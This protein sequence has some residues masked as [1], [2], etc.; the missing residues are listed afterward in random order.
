MQDT[1]KFGTERIV[2]M[3]DVIGDMDACDTLLDQ[4]LLPEDHIGQDPLADYETCPG[5]GFL[6]DAVTDDLDFAIPGLDEG[7]NPLD[8]RD[9]KHGSPLATPR[10]H[11]NSVPHN[12]LEIL[13]HLQP[14]SFPGAH[15]HPPRHSTHTQPSPLRESCRRGQGMQPSASDGLERTFICAPAA[16]DVMPHQIGTSTHTQSSPPKQCPTPVVQDPPAEARAPA[17]RTKVCGLCAETLPLSDFQLSRRSVLG[18]LAHGTYCGDCN[19]LRS[20]HKNVRIANLRHL[21]ATGKLSKESVREAKMKSE[22]PLVPTDSNMPSIRSCFLCGESK[23]LSK[24]P[25]LGVDQATARRGICCVA[26]DSVLRRAFPVPLHELRSACMD[27]TVDNLVASIVPP[28][29]KINKCDASPSSDLVGKGTSLHERFEAG[30]CLPHRLFGGPALCCV[31]LSECLE[32][33]LQ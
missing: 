33:S 32:S 13:A 19:I 8:L 11:N 15:G 2:Q 23:H 17:T 31:A 5:P 14:A 1:V 12:H 25:L 27:G 7:T 9:L 30:I 4:V 29:R 3:V 24:F 10:D 21:I 22:A 28:D 26:C 6:S 18:P 16:S 20:K